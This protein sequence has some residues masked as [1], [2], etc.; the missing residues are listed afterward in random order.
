MRY[1]NLR[2]LVQTVYRFF[3]KL[4]RK[5]EGSKNP[6]KRLVNLREV[7]QQQFIVPQDN[8]KVWQAYAQA[9]AFAGKCDRGELAQVI[10]K[11]D[12][13][14]EG[15]ILQSS[16]PI[17]PALTYLLEM[18]PQTL[19]NLD[20]AWR[21][22]QRLNQPAT[23]E[24]Q[25]Q[26][27]RQ[28]ARV[29]DTNVL[30]TRLIKRRSEGT[31][32]ATELSPVLSDFLDHHAFQPS[33]PWK[34]FLGQYRLAELL[35]VHQV[36]A[37]LDSYDEAAELAE[38][39]RD[40]R[41]AIRYLT[42]LSG[43]ETAL[44][45]L[46]LAQQLGDEAV[47]TQAHQSVA[48]SCWEAGNDVEAQ[49][50]F[51]KAGNLERASDC[52]LRLGELGRSIQLRPSLGPEWVQA[53]RSALESTVRLQIEQQEFLAAIRLLK[54]VAEAWQEKAQVA[55][56]E[57]TQHLLTEAVRTARSTFTAEL[58]TAEAAST[59]DLLKRWSLLEESAGNYLEAGLQA[60]KAQDYF[61]AAILFE[62]AS[63]F[64]QAVVALESASPETINPR[65]KAQL[66]EQGGDFFMAGLIYEQ[67]GEIDPAIA[68]Y[69][70]AKEF[71]RAAELRQRQ[72]GDEQVVLD[73][74]FKNLL[75]QAGRI[76]HLADLCAAQATEPGRSSDEKAQRWRRV[77]E[78]GEQGLVGQQWLD[79]VAIELPSIEVLDR[80][81]FEA[82]AAAWVQTARREVLADY[83]DAIGLD[84]GTSNSVVCL[85][86][87]RRGEPEVVEHQGRRQIPSVFAID[88]AGRERVGVPIL[89]LVSKS[90]RAII[91]KAKR[92][93]GTD[94]KFRVAGQDY[95]AEEVSARIITCAR[96]FA[97]EHLQK[98][99]GERVS[100]IAARTLKSVPPTD[101]INEFLEQNPPVIPLTN[102]VI[103]VPAY[104]NEAQKQATKTA[105]I[106]AG[107]TILRLI[108]EPTAACLAQR[109]RESKEETILVADLGAGTFDLSIIQA[110]QG[111]FE[112]QEIEGD[113]ALG[114]ADLD[115]ILYTH[116]AESIQ[117]EIGQEIPRNSQA[118][119]P[120]TSSL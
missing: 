3:S 77:K 52:N 12:P 46:A 99:I 96:Q 76:E 42:N 27:C 63:A 66:L 23:Q 86:N 2:R 56:A 49:E 98:K 8:D 84:L 82:Q 58:Q 28:L 5:L 51:Q 95:R 105:G 53:I 13:L 67:L 78:L 29:G 81:K 92:E 118:A 113:N 57:R 45:V 14:L 17:E 4:L 80:R 18:R 32:T 35:Q 117:A 120:V 59:T 47:I 16:L 97:R 89:E 19:V 41:S 106:L 44:R 71:L 31:L 20:A 88:Q 43:Q 39:A 110:G 70:Q 100:T 38:T 79:R 54:S 36:Y 37:V 112:V 85:Y 25:Q 61:A 83:L 72:L 119:N 87:Q 90:P 62:K 109:L 10:L 48:E 74:R 24:L 55:E 115:E 34:A 91:T 75:M 65:R 101:W 107:M 114:S 102:A 116:F 93:M 108:H 40:Y 60:E 94:R 103:T 111:V 64:G 50:H 1:L 6:Q 73:D 68:L 9:L 22:S 11:L 15:Q 69:E 33:A 30:L 26:I 7:L 104:F 21:L